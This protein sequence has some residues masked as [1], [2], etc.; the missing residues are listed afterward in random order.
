MGHYLVTVDGA[1]VGQNE[2]PNPE[3]AVIRSGAADKVN[4]DGAVKVYPLTT[5]PYG[6]ARVL[7]GD[8]L[9]M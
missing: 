4:G 3:E 7:I 1:V 8:D 9:Q 5:D 2:A 6:N